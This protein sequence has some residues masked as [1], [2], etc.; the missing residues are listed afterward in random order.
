MTRGQLCSFV[1]AL[2]F[3]TGTAAWAQEFPTT[4]LAPGCQV[5][6]APDAQ[7]LCEPQKAVFDFS[8][9]AVLADPDAPM[10][11]VAWMGTFGVNGPTGVM[12]PGSDPDDTL[13][14]VWQHDVTETGSISSAAS[15]GARP[16]N[17]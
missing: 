6:A 17:R 1:V 4:I 2:G 9:L 14:A 13:V 10:R 7:N 11:T 5:A 16:A 12:P 8:G 15:R 3:A